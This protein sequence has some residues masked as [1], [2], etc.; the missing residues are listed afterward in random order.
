MIAGNLASKFAASE[1]YGALMNRLSDL[2]DV[3]L[4]AATDEDN[5]IVSDT[6]KDEIRNNVT[7][8][9]EE[10]HNHFLETV[11]V[12]S[13]PVIEAGSSAP[14]MD[15]SGTTATA[16]LVTNAILI[17]ASLGDSRAVLS[18]YKGL[19]GGGGSRQSGSS[20]RWKNFPSVSPIQLSIDHVASD[21]TEHALVVQRGGTIR[22]ERSG[23][24]RVNGTLAITRSIGDANLSNVLSREPHVLVLD[25][26]ELGKWCG[27][28]ISEDDKD[29]TVSSFPCFVILGMCSCH[30]WK[31]N[32]LSTRRSKKH[33]SFF[34]WS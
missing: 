31:S 4:S 29:D 33:G 34:T 15:Q 32:H 19:I 18:S 5:Q 24:P 13:S 26:S 22:M 9:F 8:A 1:L 28:D 10:V 6:W 16:L 27:V 30:F 21:P 11:T 20:S 25:R 3:L 7:H 23:L 12:L 14:S 17:V 2:Q